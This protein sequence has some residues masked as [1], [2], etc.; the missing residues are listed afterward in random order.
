M[1]TGA[2]D[3]SKWNWQSIGNSVENLPDVLNPVLSKVSLRNRRV[4]VQYIPDR[5]P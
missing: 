2:N 3:S 1:A 4:E 5:R